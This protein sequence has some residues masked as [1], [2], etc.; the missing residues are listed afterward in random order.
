MLFALFRLRSAADLGRS[1]ICQCSHFWPLRHGIYS[2]RFEWFIQGRSLSC[3]LPSVTPHA[4]APKLEQRAMENWS[5]WTSR[6]ISIPAPMRR[7]D[8]LSLTESR[9]T[10]RARTRFLITER[11]PARFTPTWFQLG[12]FVDLAF[13]KR[14]QPRNSF[15]MNWLSVWAWMLLSFAS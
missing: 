3:R 7:G 6:L 8:Q 10:P 12:H 15:T 14:P 11:S 2:V 1:W 5:Q 13:R 4:F 9:C